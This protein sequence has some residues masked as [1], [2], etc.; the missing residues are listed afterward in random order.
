MVDESSESCQ[1]QIFDQSLVPPSLIRDMFSKALSAMFQK[2]VP[3]YK[4]LLSI[5]SGITSSRA[6]Y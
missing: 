3:L 2:E 5:V 1:L 6:V 4:D